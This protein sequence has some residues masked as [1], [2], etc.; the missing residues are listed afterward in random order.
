MLQ[1]LSLTIPDGQKIAILGQSG[2][3]KT[4][5]LKLLLG[6]E[7]PLAGT[8]TI[9]GTAVADLSSQRATLIA[10]LDQQPY[11]FASTVANNLHLGKLDATDE[12]LWDVLEQVN[13]KEL[14]VQLPD[15]LATPMSEM[16]SR[17]S[18]GERQ[19]FALARILL[20]DTPIV[21]LDEPTVAL[22][23]I[24][25][26][27]V[28]ETIFKTLHDKTVIWVTHHLTGI[29]LVDKVIFIENQQI[30]MAGTPAKLMA[31]EHRFQRLLALDH[32]DLM[33]E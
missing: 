18:G 33:L 26:L 23:P 32:G 19:R 6:D 25:E 4:T 7:M 30:A 28:L 11:L 21:I 31:T 10:V 27:A 14:V 15:G 29:E 12:E 5:L 13:L 1:D 24:T 9:G 3:G 22:D 17:F 8:V 20:Q 2:A 16:G